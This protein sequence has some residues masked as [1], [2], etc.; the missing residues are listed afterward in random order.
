MWNCSLWST[1]WEMLL[2]WR[3]ISDSGQSIEICN[4]FDRELQL[5]VS[6]LGYALSLV[7]HMKIQMVLHILR[8]APFSTLNCRWWSTYWDM[9]FVLREILDGDWCIEMCYLFDVKLKMVV[10]ILRY[11]TCLIWIC[12]W[13]P[14]YWNMLLSWREIVDGGRCTETSYLVELEL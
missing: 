4:S 14:T 2:I 8:Y 12:R 10:H 11:A 5:V 6:V 13:W 7:F 3:K 9:L 1:Y